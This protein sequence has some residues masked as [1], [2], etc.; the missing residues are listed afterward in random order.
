MQM[1][2]T[3]VEGEAGTLIADLT[4]ADANF[5][6]AWNRLLDRYD[7]NRIVVYKHLHKIL[8]QQA[9]K[10]NSKSIKRLLD[11][12][13]QVLLALQN[14]GRPIE[15]WDDW[16]I[17]TTTQKLNEESRKDWERRIGESKDL[18]TWE[19]LKNFPSEQ[20]R[21]LEGIENTNRREHPKLPE[22]A[23]KSVIKSYQS[24]INQQGR[25]ACDGDH[26]LFSCTS[27]K[28][29]EVK[30]R[31]ELAKKQ[32]LCFLCLYHHDD[33]LKCDKQ[34]P[35]K[36]CNRRHSTWLHED[37]KDGAGPT[38]VVTAH[39]CVENNGNPLQG[40]LATALILVQNIRG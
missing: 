28:G 34:K 4:V 14:M 26:K 24:T 15:F 9:A 2:K 23:E 19:Q 32:K 17:I 40:L 16:I 1:L 39:G 20:F 31:W 12:T 30:Q 36:K 29:M 25:A 7:N 18:P 3:L 22:K 8:T 13:D 6:I 10:N 38:T 27:F 37:R 33:K 5:I 21:I 35:C 11:T